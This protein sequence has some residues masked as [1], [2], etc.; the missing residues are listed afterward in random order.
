MDLN[1]SPWPLTFLSA[2]IAM[3]VAWLIF[4]SGAAVVGRGTA[5]SKPA[6]AVTQSARKP[7]SI[8]LPLLALQFVL[9]GASRRRRRW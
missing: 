8:L 5:H 7:A 2:A 6:A 1:F 3:T 4:Y 9:R